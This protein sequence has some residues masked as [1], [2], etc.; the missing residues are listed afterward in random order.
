MR[1]ELPLH[2]L[3]A[4]AAMDELDGIFQTDD[5]ERTRGVQVIDHRCEGG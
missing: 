2:Y 5:I 4:L 3:A 1:A